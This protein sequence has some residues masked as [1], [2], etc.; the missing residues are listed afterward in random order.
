MAAALANRAMG[1]IVGSAV[2]DAAAQPLHWVYDLQKLQGILA[3]DPNPEFRSESANPFYRRQTGQQSCYG[4]QA[5]VL[6]ES[7]SDC[8]GLN[9]E[10]LTQRTLK[11]FG[12]GSEYDTPVN[13]PYRDRSGPRPQL[14]IDGPWR[15][16]SLK[17]FLKNVDAGKEETGCETD[18]QIDGI[19]KMAPVVAFYAGKPDML[20]KVEQ[21][22][23]VTQNSDECVAETL[24]A[25]RILEH[26]ILNGPDSNVLDKVLDQLK[27]PNRKQPQDLDRAVIGHIHQVKENLSKTP[28][29]LIPSRTTW[30]DD[31]SGLPGAFQAALHGVLTATSYEQAVRDTMS[32]GG[33]TCSRGSFIGACLGAQVGLEGIPASWASKTLR[34]NSVLEHAKKIT[35]HH[36]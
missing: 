12:P 21:A 13:D 36:Q 9:V 14:P 23:R 1:A 35:K 27:D 17:S 30:L 28:Q 15:H 31:L 32:C 33:C 29:Q 8:G 2:A 11:F 22:I 4:D 26:F 20:E 10:D 7:L 16:G 3:Q 19:A 6:L 25:A 24:A 34:Y 5:F 18:F